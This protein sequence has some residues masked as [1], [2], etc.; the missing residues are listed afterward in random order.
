MKFKVIIHPAEEGG[1]WVEVPALKGCYTQGESLDE[2]KKYI[3]EAIGLYLDEDIKPSQLDINDQVI[4][5]AN[6]ENCYKELM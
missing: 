3:K 6:T 4:G 5:E 1:Y 2:I